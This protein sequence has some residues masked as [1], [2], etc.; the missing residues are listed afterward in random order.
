MRTAG[1][2]R[3][4]IRDRRQAVGFCR[5]GWELGLGRPPAGRR[6]KVG[7]E[8]SS[9]SYSRRVVASKR[10]SAGP[11]VTMRSAW[12]RPRGGGAIQTHEL[13]P[14]DVQ[15]YH[16]RPNK[17]QPADPVLP[18][19]PA[20]LFFFCFSFKKLYKLFVCLEKHMYM[21]FFCQKSR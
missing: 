1:A 10:Q 21:R 13:G 7:R 6:N 12:S 14:G 16:A 8:P 5:G 15:V 9:E 2:S 20:A 11:R 19:G 4:V 3:Q 18:S 17:Q